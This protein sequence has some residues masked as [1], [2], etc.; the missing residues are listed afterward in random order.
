MSRIPVR[1]P[2]PR[3]KYHNVPTVVD[4]LRFDSHREAARYQELKLLQQAG[5]ISGLATQPR[6]DLWYAA[7]RL[8]EYRGDFSY[9]QE[10]KTVV[11]DVKGMRTAVYRLKK[12]LM[13]ALRGIEIKE[14]R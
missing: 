8:C 10:G 1:L 2:G 9:Q 13:L 12:K 7:V 14:I 3:R 11:E 4:N 5:K 6:F